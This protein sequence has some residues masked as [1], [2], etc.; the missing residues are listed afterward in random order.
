MREAFEKSIGSQGTITIVSGLPR[1]GTSM[2]MQMLVKGGMQAFTD[3]KREAD[4]NNKKGY[5]EHELIKSLGQNKQ[6]LRQVG[7]KVVKIISHLLFHLPHIYKYKIVFMDRVI[8]EVM[9]SQHK[10]LGRLGKEGGVDKANST[11]LLKT[12]EDS[13]KKAIDW[14]NKHPKYVEILLVPYAETIKTPLEQAKKVNKFLGGH[15]DELKMASVV[16]KSLYR[17]KTQTV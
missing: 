10:M 8:E 15:L 1:S 7:D 17:E 2:M 16:D 14:C 4:E 3:G 11:A 5:F 6:V 12:F 9:T 13:R